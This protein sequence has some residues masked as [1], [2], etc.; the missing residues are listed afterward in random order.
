[1]EKDCLCHHI[2]PFSNSLSMGCDSKRP[3]SE[4]PFPPSLSREWVDQRVAYRPPRAPL[5]A[6]WVG[7]SPEVPVCLFWMGLKIHKTDS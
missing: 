7:S 5:F 4:F 1:M 3:P 6:R 2:S